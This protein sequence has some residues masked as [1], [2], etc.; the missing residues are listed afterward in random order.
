MA[1]W[2]AGGAQERARREEE[3]SD[4]ALYDSFAIVNRDARG[5]KTYRELSQALYRNIGVRVHASPLKRTA[6]HRKWRLVPKY[7]RRTSH[8]SRGRSGGRG[9]CVISATKTEA[10]ISPASPPVKVKMFFSVMVIRATRTEGCLV[11]GIEIR[12]HGTKTVPWDQNY[13]LKVLWND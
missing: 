11:P 2:H 1:A 8:R 12:S 10:H 6:D 5:D 3:E 13:F 9:R 4:C 7:T